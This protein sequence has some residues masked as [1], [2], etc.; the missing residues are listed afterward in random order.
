MSA[1]FARDGAFGYAFGSADT[2]L[3]ASVEPGSYFAAVTPASGGSAIAMCELYED[4]GGSSYSR[5]TNLSTRAFVGSESNVLIGGFA[6]QG[7]GTELVLIRGIGPSLA[8]YGVT[9]F[10]P[11]PMITVYDSSG[12]AIESNSKWNP[13]IELAF[14][15]AGAFPLPV[16]SADAALVLTLSPGAYTFVLQ[17]V[18]GDSGIAL[19]EIYEIAP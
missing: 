3:L 5:L 19:A 2:A 6:V 1:A 12:T 10:L 14:A 17:G 8:G 13:D 7:S 15:K 11:D 4:D 18:S 16:G 9:G